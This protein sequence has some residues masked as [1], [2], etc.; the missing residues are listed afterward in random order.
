MG[1]CDFGR[2]DE[3]FPFEDE[4]IKFIEG[5]L[6]QWKTEREFKVKTKNE[7]LR[8]FVSSVKNFLLGYPEEEKLSYLECLL[9]KPIPEEN[10]QTFFLHITELPDSIPEKAYLLQG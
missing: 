7:E 10:R 6:P 3:L 4:A 9:E 5:I 2:E 1:C 8:H